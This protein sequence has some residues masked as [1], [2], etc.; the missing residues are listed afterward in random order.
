[1]NQE[2]KARLIQERTELRDRLNKLSGFI[3]STGFDPLDME[4]RFLLCQQE[5]AMQTYEKIL[6]RRILINNAAT[7]LDQVLSEMEPD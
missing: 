3:A 7:E 5:L 6:T 1:M 4:N 2:T